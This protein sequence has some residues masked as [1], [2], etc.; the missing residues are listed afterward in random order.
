MSFENPY[1]TKH[2]L[3]ANS[4]YYFENNSKINGCRIKLQHKSNKN[5]HF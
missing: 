5:I 1:Q 4:E 2:S 3:L